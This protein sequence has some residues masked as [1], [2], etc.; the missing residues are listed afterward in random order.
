VDFFKSSLE[1]SALN[2]SFA[3]DNPEG[4]VVFRAV[5]KSYCQFNFLSCLVWSAS[6]FPSF[7]RVS[8]L[9]FALGAFSHAFSSINDQYHGLN[10]IE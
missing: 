2:L 4:F 10:D 3:Q 5:E 1:F 8:D 9:C 7:S 6:H